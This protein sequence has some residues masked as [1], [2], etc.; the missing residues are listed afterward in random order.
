MKLVIDSLLSMFRACQMSSAMSI[1]SRISKP[2][3][4]S[5]FA[6]IK[7]KN[8]QLDPKAALLIPREPIRA[9]QAV[10]PQH[11]T[12]R[13]SICGQQLAQDRPMN[14]IP[15]YPFDAIEINSHSFTI[16][17]LSI[18]NSPYLHSKEEYSNNFPLF[19][20]LSV[21]ASVYLLF[22]FPLVSIP[23]KWAGV[24]FTGTG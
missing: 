11:R 2:W 23:A 4:V 24:F 5:L 7:D 20:S 3:T 22:N 17:Q 10:E 15:Q 13:L 16:L 6:S 9:E 14:L 19:K 8:Q 12:L 1:S 21:H 18:R